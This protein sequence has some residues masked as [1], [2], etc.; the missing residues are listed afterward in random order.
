MLVRP[1]AFVEAPMASA[2]AMLENAD[3]RFRNDFVFWQQL[4]RLGAQT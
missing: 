1:Q 3:P 4:A 2:R